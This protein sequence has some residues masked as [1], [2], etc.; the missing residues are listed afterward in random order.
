MGR[1][2]RIDPIDRGKGMSVQSMLDFQVQMRSHVDPCTFAVF[3]H[4]PESQLDKGFV[5][6][7]KRFVPEQ[8]ASPHKLLSQL[9][10]RS[11]QISFHEDYH[12]WQGL[13][14]PFVHRYATLTFRHV[15]QAFRKLSGM[16]PDFRRWDCLLPEFERLSLEEKIGFHGS[17]LVWGRGKA[18]F[19]EPIDDEI[20]IRPLDLL[21]CA[22]S[23]AE[24]QFSAL[25]DKSDPILFRRWSKRNPAYLEPYEF[26]CRFLGDRRLGLRCILPLINAAFHTS[27]PVRTFYELLG[28]AWGSFCTGNSG[29]MAFL[30][31]PEP[32]RWSELFQDWLEKIPYEAELDSDGKILGSPYHRL[33]AGAWMGGSY[34]PDGERMLHPFLGT[35]ARKWIEEQNTNPLLGMLM[36]Q[37]GWVN[38]ET[39]WKAR[40]DFGPA[41]TVYRFH[42][43]DNDDVTLMTGVADGSG[44]ISMPGLGPSDWRVFVAD[45]LA[46]YGAVRR[47]SGAH[48]DAGQRTCHHR[49]CPY[50]SDNFCN[51]Y[52]II[53]KDFR[54]CGF[55]ERIE[56]L[57]HTYRSI[58]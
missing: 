39:F 33:T 22:T 20:R 12:Y 29:W 50:Y 42:L 37:P 35:I 38:P 43:E 25:G 34:G 6:E 54:T 11:Q 15:F 44:F 17:E 40:D 21:E 2:L 46:M 31:Q 23:I 1:E 52:P 28:R 14:L 53:P 30:A 55:S 58:S 48:F 45:M 24:F 26:A 18:E 19:P 36:D 16:D 32:C 49:D 27:E 47:A 8:G 4:L 10:K 9:P 57:T 56:R 3:I 13:H 51:A 7:L 5:E 41:L